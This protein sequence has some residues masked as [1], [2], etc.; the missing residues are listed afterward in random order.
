M[1]ISGLNQVQKIISFVLCSIPD[2]LTPFGRMMALLEWYLTSFHMGRTDST[3]KKPYNPVIGETFHCSW[4]V[5][6]TNP[7]F[8]EL[9]SLNQKGVY[10]TVNLNAQPRSKS[11]T[12]NSATD[13]IVHPTNGYTS[14]QCSRLT[15]DS[16]TQMSP[17][18]ATTQESTDETYKARCTSAC[19]ISAEVENRV[20]T[21]TSIENV[22]IT[23]TA[24]QVSHHPPGMLL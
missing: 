6:N 23:Y 8:K 19:S 9:T 18:D 13:T 22:E 7:S 24:E 14:G 1:N 10:E 3:A 17:P 5:H 15:N 20:I 21:D 16:E 12:E 4:R 2:E 11:A